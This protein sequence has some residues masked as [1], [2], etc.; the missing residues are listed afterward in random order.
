MNGIIAQLARALPCHGRGCGFE[1]RWFRQVMPS[2]KIVFIGDPALKAKNSAVKNF[3]SKKLK[4][5]IRDLKDT[6]KKE[7]LVGLAAPQIAEN[8]KVFV[9]QP[10]KTKARDFGRADRCRV[11]INPNIVSYSKTVSL[12]YE[13]CGCVPDLFGPV[14][15]PRE[16][17][18]D[19]FDEN[20][21]RFSLF[22]DGLLARV[23]QHEYDHLYGIEFVEKISNYK[24]I[25]H[26]DYYI[27]NIRNSKAQ[28]EASLITKIKT[29][30]Y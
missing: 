18:I 27:K 29:S 7:G 12:I 4:N 10:R 25:V 17:K 5:L 30:K 8:Y 24:K 9:T 1:S 13:G 3:G 14:I 16:I 11:Y 28:N 21:N 23:I 26:R 15:R 6:M 20:G 19:A 22:C 2:K